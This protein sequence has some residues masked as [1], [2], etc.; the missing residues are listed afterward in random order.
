[1]SKDALDQAADAVKGTIDDARDAI[2]EGSHRSAADGERA[3]REIAGDEM[4][5]GERAGSAV[6][7]AKHRAEAEVDRIKRDLRHST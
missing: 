5:P 7:E 1:M 3:K 6:N 4:T 2:H